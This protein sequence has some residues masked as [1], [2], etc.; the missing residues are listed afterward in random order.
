VQV[1]PAAAFQALSIFA[2]SALALFD[3]VTPKIEAMSLVCPKPYPA[4]FMTTPAA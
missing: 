4:P 1:P 3:I 2:A